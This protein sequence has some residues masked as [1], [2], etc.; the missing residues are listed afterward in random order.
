MQLRTKLFLLVSLVALLV[1]VLFV[2]V[3][4]RNAERNLQHALDQEGAT[5]RAAVEAGMQAMLA[6]MLQLATLIGD[7][8]RVQQA[9]LRG[10]RA[11]EAEGGGAGGEQAAAARQELNAL[12]AP[13]WERMQHEFGLRQLQFHLAPGALSFLR[14]HQP[15]RFGDRM[16][17]VRPIIVETNASQS[18][19]SGFELGRIMGGL[20]GVVPV[21]ATDPQ[22]GKRVHVGALEAGSSFAALLQ[23]LGRS[24][25]Q[26]VAILLKREHVDA[27]MWREFIGRHVEDVPSVCE[28]MVEAT[29]GPGIYD[30]MRQPAFRDLYHPSE[31]AQTYL[32][33]VQGRTLAVTRFP[34]YEFATSVEPSRK[35]VGGFVAWTDVSERVLALERDNQQNIAIALAGFV[36]LELVLFLGFRFG[37]QRLEAAVRERTRALGILDRRLDG[38]LHSAAEGILGLDA[39]LRVTFA[40]KAAASLTGWPL[41]ALRGR[42]LD[43]LIRQGRESGGMGSLDRLLEAGGDGRMIE[44]VFQ[45]RGGGGFPAEC[46]V[47]PMQEDGAAGAVLVFRDITERREM[48]SRIRDL[49]YHDPLTGLPN[50]A[51]LEE[52]MHDAMAWSRRHHT[53]LSLLYIDLDGFKQVNDRFG[54]GAG[55][56]VLQVTSERLR[57]C[58][59]EVD[60]LSRLGGDEFVAILRVEQGDARAGEEVAER[61]IHALRQPIDLDQGQAGIGASIGIAVCPWDTGDLDACMRLADQ[62]M[63]AAKRTGKNR[64]VRYS[65]ELGRDEVVPA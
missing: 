36:L 21:W 30:L 40:N 53:H 13:T 11:V 63:Y 7:D 33:P 58:V 28:C 17:D 18:A 29:S 54:H 9:F 35:A 5:I 19:H 1:D 20:R 39:G 14:V 59:R 32:V 25:H 56:R 47:S 37:Y 43:E 55:D 46:S 12:L 64:W 41:E 16:D 48:E 51:L 44:A 6:N 49:A 3:N 50:R 8:T 45:R 65:S 62:A 60:I 15:D 57:Q 42:R 10:R 27:R 24:N 23:Q 34:L 26:A 52:K 31:G 61:I 4:Q 22:T 38:I 2:V